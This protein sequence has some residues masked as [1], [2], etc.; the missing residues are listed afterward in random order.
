MLLFI[1][2]IHTLVWAFMAVCTSYILYC[3]IRRRINKTLYAATFIMILEGIILLVNNLECPFATIAKKITT[4][5]SPGFDIFLPEWFIPY[6]IPVFTI[7][8]T[9]GVMLMGYNI[10]RQK[11]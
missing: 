8:V 5:H 6:N 3:G 1:K 4:D 10:Y 11:T 9:L 2:I 7:L